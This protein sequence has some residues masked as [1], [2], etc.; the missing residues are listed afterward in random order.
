MH[1]HQRV[2]SSSSLLSGIPMA[3]RRSVKLKTC[4]KILVDVPKPLSNNLTGMVSSRIREVAQSSTPLVR[5][6]KKRPRHMSLK[7]SYKA[8]TEPISPKMLNIM[9]VFL[10]PSDCT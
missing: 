3:M 10:G 5:P 6:K 8:I 1:R 7:L 4:I 9:M 2:V